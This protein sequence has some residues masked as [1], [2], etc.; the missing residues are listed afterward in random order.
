MIKMS[1]FD[2]IYVNEITNSII[3]S[4]KTFSENNGASNGNRTL[5]CY[6]LKLNS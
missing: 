5:V 2:N 3:D 1:G 6:D 4:S